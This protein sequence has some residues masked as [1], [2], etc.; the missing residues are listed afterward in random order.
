MMTIIIA[1]AAIGIALLLWHFFPETIDRWFRHFMTARQIFWGLFSILVAFVF[2][3]TGSTTL[4]LLGAMILIALTLTI[5][6]EDP[7][8]LG[9]M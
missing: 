2:I 8:E 4:V 6:I 7:F 5:V 3:G 9:G 1:L